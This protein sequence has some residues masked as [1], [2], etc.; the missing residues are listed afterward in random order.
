[1][2]PFNNN[3]ACPNARFAG[4]KGVTTGTPAPPP[5]VPANALLAADGTPILAADGSYILVSS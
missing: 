3:L 5:A 4:G 1:M 2:T